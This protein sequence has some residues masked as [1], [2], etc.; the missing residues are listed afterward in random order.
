MACVLTR[1]LSLEG[2]VPL[3]RETWKKCYRESTVFGKDHIS[4]GHIRRVKNS[5]F[6]GGRHMQWQHVEWRHI[7][8]LTHLKPINALTAGVK[9]RGRG[10][11][12]RKRSKHLIANRY[13][14]LLRTGQQQQLKGQRRALDS[15]LFSFIF[16]ELLELLLT[17]LFT[18]RHDV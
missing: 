12:K 9:I 5:S 4:T 13:L 16:S 18:M 2:L 7:W 3:E 14:Y 8:N 15:G 10:R 17:S 1:P 11:R 6:F